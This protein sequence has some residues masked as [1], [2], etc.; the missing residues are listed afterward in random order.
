MC[1]R[2]FS[3]SSLYPALFSLSLSL[4]LSLPLVGFGFV[5]VC[6]LCLT[7]VDEFNLLALLVQNLNLLALL[8]RYAAG[9]QGRLAVYTAVEKYRCLQVQKYLLH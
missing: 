3:L 7:S 1:A 5:S 2:A 9:A 6:E 8:V 4:S